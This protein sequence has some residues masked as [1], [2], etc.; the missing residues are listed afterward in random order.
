[1]LWQLV[2]GQGQI[3]RVL[4][5]PDSQAIA[6]LLGMHDT[7]RLLVIDTRLEPIWQSAQEPIRAAWA[8]DSSCLAYTAH[9]NGRSELLMYERGGHPEAYWFERDDGAASDVPDTPCIQQVRWD[10]LYI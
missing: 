7:A 9:S 2:P 10:S 1:M 3:H 8:P 5:A 4:W 6:C